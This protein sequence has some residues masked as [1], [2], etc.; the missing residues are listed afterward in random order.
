M[1]YGSGWD[2][3]VEAQPWSDFHW[4]RV[5]GKTMLELVILS[6]EPLWYVGHFDRG[7]MVP[8][9]REGCRLCAEGVGAQ[10]RYVFS[11]IE[12]ST[13]RIGLVEVGKSVGQLIRDWTDRCGGL[14]GMWVEAYKHTASKNSRMEVRYIDNP[15]PN[16][17]LDQEG[18][19]CKEALVATW[20]KAKVDLPAWLEVKSAP[21]SFLRGHL[22]KIG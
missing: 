9:Y 22:E 14:R 11:A 16:G 4:F 1:T 3:P 8:C 6:R 17:I 12:I 10:V 20:Q 21:G 13:R 15:L 18:P 5:T 7:R 19:D 2:V